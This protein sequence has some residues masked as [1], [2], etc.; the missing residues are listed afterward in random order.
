MVL[1]T[2]RLRNHASTMRRPP[3]IYRALAAAIPE[4]E[5]N[6]QGVIRQRE[7]NGI[8]LETLRSLDP[9]AARPFVERAWDLIDAARGI[10]GGNWVDFELHNFIVERGVLY[11]VDPVYEIDDLPSRP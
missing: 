10:I 9:V 1:R 11:W 5:I 8:S 3:A 6:E 7:I 4:T 2:Q